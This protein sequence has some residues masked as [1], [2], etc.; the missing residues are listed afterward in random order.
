M[1]FSFFMTFV[2]S[3]KLRKQK[4]KVFLIPSQTIFWTDL[5]CLNQSGIQLELRWYT[6]DRPCMLCVFFS[7][8]SYANHQQGVIRL[9]LWR[10]TS[11]IHLHLRE[12]TDWLN[13]NKCTGEEVVRVL[14]QG[15]QAII[16]FLPSLMEQNQYNLYSC[17]IKPWSLMM[18]WCFL[19]VPRSP[20]E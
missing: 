14:V 1:V 4:L 2:L 13:C 8:L 17:P 9:E 15:K 3:K 19:S 20:I 6:R 10:Q 16:C 11:N 12:L 7:S 5:S 18:L